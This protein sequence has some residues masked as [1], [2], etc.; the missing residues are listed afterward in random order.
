MKKHTIEDFLLRDKKRKTTVDVSKY[1][2]MIYAY[3][4]ASS[5]NGICRTS[6]IKLMLTVVPT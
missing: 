3:S 6:S 1:G 2:H 5:L 4:A